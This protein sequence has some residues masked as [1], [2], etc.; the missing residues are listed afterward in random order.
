MNPQVGVRRCDQAA[1][2]HSVRVLREPAGLFSTGRF[3]WSQFPGC[4]PAEEVFGVL[5]DRRV[6]ELGCG[7][8]ANA[9]VLAHSGAAV[10]GVDIAA[11]NIV[12]ART[13]FAEQEPRPTFT[14]CPAED[15]LSTTGS[16]FDYVYSVFGALSFADP[17]TLLPLV[18]RCLV[19]DGRLIFSVRHPEW[20]RGWL[21]PQQGG[22][23]IPYRLP[24]T[25]AIVRRFNLSR[26]EWPAV[27]S[28]YGFRTDQLLDIVAPASQRKGAGAGTTP[29]PCCLL[30]AAAVTNDA[31]LQPRARGV[32]GRAK[33][34]TPAG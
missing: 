13:R 21:P 5:K 10:H 2:R 23:V 18:R 8:G 32:R 14:T 3:E 1:W 9:V 19:A 6:L 28:T 22:R 12:Q 33:T 17:F 31:N 11:A 24:T 26:A 15:F 7:T 34:S 29:R 20:D 30:I 16:T 4:G 27:L 25:G